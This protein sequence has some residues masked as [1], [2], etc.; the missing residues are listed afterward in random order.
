MPRYCGKRS[1]HSLSAMHASSSGMRW[2]SVVVKPRL[3]GGAGSASLGWALVGGS[4]GY[5]HSQYALRIVV[6][7]L[8]EIAYR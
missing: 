7:G 8:C 3:R 2:D 1:H 4:R 5:S 6:H